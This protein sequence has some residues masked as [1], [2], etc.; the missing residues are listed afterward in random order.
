MLLSG[1][2]P[3]ESNEFIFFLMFLVFFLGK[4]C[5]FYWIWTRK[6]SNHFCK[7]NQEIP[8]T[9]L[10]GISMIMCSNF[11]DS[12]ISSVMKASSGMESII[13]V[14]KIVIL[15]STLR[16]QYQYSGDEFNKAVIDPY[17]DD[18]SSVFGDELIGTCHFFWKDS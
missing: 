6:L 17:F 4:S 7:K 16:W 3:A 13:L 5:Y 11:G 15:V 9:F 1:Y 18:R 8:A 10:E 14:I 12:F 2:R